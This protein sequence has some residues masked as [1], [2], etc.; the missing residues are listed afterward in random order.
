[1][2][3]TCGAA[4]TEFH[5]Q[6]AALMPSPFIEQEEFRQP[7]GDELSASYASGLTADVRIKFNPPHRHPIS[8]PVNFQLREAWQ[9]GFSDGIGGRVMEQGLAREI[10]RRARRG[11]AVYVAAS[12]RLAEERGG[13]LA[14]G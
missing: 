8:A 6:G 14:D 12:T 4:H 3:A 13:A 11:D 9:E 7:S 1:M 5:L 2:R 10:I